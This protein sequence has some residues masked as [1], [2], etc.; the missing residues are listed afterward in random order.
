MDTKSGAAEAIGRNRLVVCLL[1]LGLLVGVAVVS[2]SKPESDR[3]NPQARL[4]YQSLMSGVQGASE[5]EHFS[6]L[7]ELSKSA[8]AVVLAKPSDVFVTRVMSGEDE[9]GL[10]MIGVSLSS[11][12]VL[13]GSA[14]VMHNGSVVVEFVG[15]SGDGTGIAMELK[16][17]LAADAP[18]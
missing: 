16:S 14:D 10:S 9:R 11:V 1:A 7:E 4:F 13:R 12:D 2:G 17:I 15:R 18:A 5:S 8:T 6:T 3:W